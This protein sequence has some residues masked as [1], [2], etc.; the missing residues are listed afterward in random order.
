MRM[1]LQG[2]K[3]TH[4]FLSLYNKDSPFQHQDPRPPSQ[5]S[6]FLKTHD[7]LKPLEHAG[8][9]R[10][11][12]AASGDIAVA[13][14]GPAEVGRAASV[15]HVLPG[16]IG[17]YS[18]THVSDPSP[19]AM[20]KPERGTCRGVDVERKPEPYY[21]NGVA[22]APQ[23]AAGVPVALWDESA[24]KDPGSRGQW[25]SSFAASGSGSFGS[26]SASRHH[27]APEKPRLMESASRSSRGFDDE[28][29]DD[30]EFGK[31]EG[32]S[33]HKELTV[34]LD[35]KGKGGDHDQRPNTPRSKHSAT[36]QRRRSKINDRFQILREL[37]PHSD[38][39]RDKASFLLE[40]IEYIRFLQEKV[41]K[42]ESS[43]PGWSQDNTKLMP[44]NNNESPGDGISD[45]SQVMKNGSAPPG[46]MFSGSDNSIPVAPAMVSTAQNPTDSDMAAGLS[47][48]AMETP[49]NFAS[50]MA[51]TPILLRPNL[52]S[53]IG[54]ETSIAQSQQRLVA[55]ADN[56]TTQVQPQW[57]RP[58]GS[59]DCAV[60]GEI[61]NEQEL[62][63]DEGTI[64]MSSA[65]SQGLLT[66]LTQALQSSGIDLSQASISV[67][68]NLGKRAINKR[69]AAT[70]TTSGA[71]DHEDPVSANQTMGHSRAG[72]S[73]EE[74]SQ[75]PK[76]HK[77]DNS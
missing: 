24:A 25:Q 20:V 53:F 41:Q 62:T 3:T 68:I 39:K 49:T 12:E 40:V 23:Y 22:Y 15:E 37:I 64:S 27:P 65:Y 57:L 43:I 47:Y 36:E 9:G 67:Q 54:R 50:K 18:I 35:G 17:T 2:K 38:Q 70:V 58:S 45:P 1:E 33:S 10:R 69:P 60:S 56:M 5:G 73:V 74:S 19:L 71:K 26:P 76:R 7:F 75:A 6:C 16:G 4:D 66:T 21:A 59:A 51:V 61:L 63:V 32:S 8:K 30:E 14:V 28:D 34:K 29:D 42:Y 11:D 48:K 13:C 52:Y 46:Y 31:R 77:A 55:D 72:C 44:W